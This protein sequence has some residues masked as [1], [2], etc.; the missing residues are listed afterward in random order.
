M[1]RLVLRRRTNPHRPPPTRDTV[2]MNIPA[3]VG[4][5]G[6]IVHRAHLYESRITPD[7]VRASIRRGEIVRV[8]RDWVANVDCAPALRR[9]VRIGGRLT[10]ISAAS[11]LKLWTIDDERFHVA[12]PSTAS[13]LKLS[14]PAADTQASEVVH[15]SEPPLA[16]TTRIA[17]DPI[18]N[19]LVA[20]AR[21]QPHENSVAV[22]DSALN[23]KLVARPQLLRLATTVGGRFADVVAESDARA[24]SG[25]ETLPRIRLARRGVVMV[26]Q[27]R[28]DGHQV[29]GLIGQ[30]LVLQFDGDPF[31][32]TKEQRQRDRREDGR[33]VLQ[34][35]TVLRYGYSDV[36]T[37]WE[38]TEEQIL[39]AMAQGL[40]LWSTSPA[41]QPDPQELLRIAG[42]P[43]LI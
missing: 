35:F 9:A 17:I 39:S 25:I 21:C 27:V 14:P 29:D 41:L 32:S 10:C 26:P 2:A 33:L 22:I 37:D 20:V 11:H 6:G 7:A 40:H 3:A 42:G 38:A 19:V 23:K 12:A 31:H 5:F 36:M 1:L 24:D 15:W 18:E 4:E 28:V 34:G 8:R 13:R 30:R 16:V 43:G